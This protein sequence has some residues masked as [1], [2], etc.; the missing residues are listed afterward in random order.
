[1]SLVAVSVLALYAS[2]PAAAADSAGIK[3]GTRV[4]VH[5]RDAS[6]AGVVIV[7]GNIGSSDNVSVTMVDAGS[8]AVKVPLASIARIDVS[9]GRHRHTRTGAIAGGAFGLVGGGVCLAAG[10]GGNGATL[11]RATVVWAGIGGLVGFLS[12]GEDWED[13]PVANVRFG[14]APFCSR[15]AVAIAA[16]VSWR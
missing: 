11:A 15:R 12:Q 16:V 1:M 9:R 2:M 4:R 3:A 5:Y 7:T 14:V 8:E 13:V 6:T 10:C